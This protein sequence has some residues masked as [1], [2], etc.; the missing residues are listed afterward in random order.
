MKTISLEIYALLICFGATVCFSIWFGIGTYSLVGVFNPELTLSSWTYERHQSNDLFWRE[1]E[2]SP[3][4]FLAREKANT[5]VSKRPTEEILTKKRLENY[6]Q[7]LVIEA[8]S[9]KQTILETIIIL[10][11]CLFLFFTHWR[12]AKSV[13]KQAHQ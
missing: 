4:P 12:L 3:N 10:V 9:N 8:R 7:K 2:H 6:Q 11:V 5:P 13:R 1:K